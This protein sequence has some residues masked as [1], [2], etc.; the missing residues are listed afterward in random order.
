MFIVCHIYCLLHS[1]SV[2]FLVCHI[3]CLSHSLSVTFMSVTFIVCHIHW[4]SHSLSVT[5]I[6]CHIYFLTYIVCHIPW[7]WQSLLVTFV[8][9]HIPSLMSVISLIF[10]IPWLHYSFSFF[11]FLCLW[12]CFSIWNIM[13]QDSSSQR[14]SRISG[15]PGFSLR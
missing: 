12:P 5:F 3:I 6:I 9:H 2:T 7:L 1:F 10:L 8:A 4:L 15:H 14:H 11:F 13:F